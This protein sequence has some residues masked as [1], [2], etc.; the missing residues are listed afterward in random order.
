MVPYFPSR[1]SLPV[2]IREMNRETL[3]FKVP[4]WARPDSLPGI[5]LRSVD[6]SSKNRAADQK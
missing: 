6:T 1:D 4:H 5:L 3:T 2:D